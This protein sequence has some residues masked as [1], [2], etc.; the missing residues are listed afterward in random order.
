MQFFGCG[1]KRGLRS[2]RRTHFSDC[3][4]IVVE[5]ATEQVYEVLYCVAVYQNP[6][7]WNLSVGFTKTGHA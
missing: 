3:S 7:G 6:N 2:L 5:C 4:G 1:K